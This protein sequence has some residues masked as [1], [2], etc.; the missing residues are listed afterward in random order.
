MRS[1][2]PRLCL[3]LLVF[4][5]GSCSY[6]YDLR[7]VVIGGQLAFIVDPSSPGDADCIRTIEVSADRDEPYAEP[8]PGDDKQLVLNGGVYW[9]DFRGVESCENP[10]PVF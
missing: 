1:R 6:A 9:W 3:P 10:F 4:L 2:K 5:L 8:A 7:A